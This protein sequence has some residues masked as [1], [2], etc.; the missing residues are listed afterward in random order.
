MN[1]E[2]LRT[3]LDVAQTG[4][5]HRSAE[6]LNVSQSTVST[7]IKVLESRLDR[8]LFNRLKNGVVLTGAGRRLMRHADTAVRGWEQGRQALSLPD[9]LRAACALGIQ[10]ALAESLALEWLGWMRQRHPDVAIRI[11]ADYSAPLARL[12]DD[13]LLDMAVLF[14]PRHRPGL[15]VETL[16]VDELLLVSARPAT[17]QHGVPEPY[18]YV[19][20][21][22]DF[23][24]AHADAFA[25]MDLPRI[26]IG[27]PNV[28]LNRILSDGGSAYLAHA[29]VAP[30]LADGQLH[31]V[32]GA[33]RFEN[34][35]YLVYRDD[36]V[37]AEVQ[38]SALDGLRQIAAGYA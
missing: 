12:L 36:P 28:A 8:T 22:Y 23:R 33:P 4:S 18:I 27:L 10:Q 7:R 2:H 15:T 6:R 38:Q 20:W 30:W 14:V 37:D 26:T 25:E 5:F 31:E 32:V 34:P 35:T 13:A 19:D 29:S 24:G 3:F 21:T 1:I 11:E 16:Y 17:W 9:E